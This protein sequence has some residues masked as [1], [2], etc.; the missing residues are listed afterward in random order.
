[1]PSFRSLHNASVSWFQKK[2]HDTNTENS[3]PVNHFG[4]RAAHDGCTK[5]R[6]KLS[7]PFCGESI[8]Q[9]TW[10]IFFFLTSA[11]LLD[12]SNKK[13]LFIIMTHVMRFSPCTKPWCTAQWLNRG[14]SSVDGDCVYSHVTCWQKGFLKHSWIAADKMKPLWG[15]KPDND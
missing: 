9:A 7:G 15:K 8:L 2:M 5:D 3:P 11:V 1:M 10:Q 13:R 4:G 14:L 6:L 12:G